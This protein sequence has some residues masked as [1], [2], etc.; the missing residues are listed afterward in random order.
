MTNHPWEKLVRA[1][2]LVWILLTI[3][4]QV[5]LLPLRYERML[6]L[7]PTNESPVAFTDWSGE[8]IQQSARLAGVSPAVIATC[9]LAAS[10]VCLLSFWVV[11]ALLFWKK[12]ETWSWLLASFILFSTAPG[13]SNLKLIDLQNPS[14]MNSVFSTIAG[15]AFPTFF[16]FL[17]LFPN[18]N[19]VPRF[20]RYLAF[21]PYFLSVLGMFT[22][23]LDDVS[24]FLIIAYALGGLVSQIYRYLNVSSPSERQQTKW[25]V[26]ALGVFL[27]LVVIQSLTPILFTVLATITV[28]GFW[29]EFLGNGVVGVLLPVILPLAIG[30]SILRYKLWEIDL[31]IRR[32]LLYSTLTAVLG[33]VYFGGVTLL[34]SLFVGLSGQGSPASLVISTLL[35]AAL[36]NPLRRRLQDIIDGRFYRQKYDAEQALASFS[37][38]AQ[39]ETD[40]ERLSSALLQVAQRTIQPQQISLWMRA[41]IRRDALAAERQGI[42]K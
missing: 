31:V 8:Q 28:P 16:V 20:T 10:L 7:E 5:Y 13:F 34:Q 25:I 15:I 1:I 39:K 32:T 3:V 29:W 30:A 4:L 35:I 14:W 41:S 36:F 12:A 42:I 9:M 17:Y 38:A 21:V 40:V 26:T 22:K 37:D 19:F 33:L 11:G 6:K 18:G 23:L 24:S 27:S 2:L